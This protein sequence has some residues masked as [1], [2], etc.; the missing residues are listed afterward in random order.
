MLKT[1]TF[2]TN[3]IH[4]VRWINLII[5]WLCVIH[6]VIIYPLGWEYIIF[7]DILTTIL[8]LKKRKIL[9]NNSGI[10]GFLNDNQNFLKIH[11]VILRFAIMYYR[12]LFEPK[13][14]GNVK[15]KLEGCWNSFY[16]NVYYK[17]NK[18]SNIFPQIINPNS[19]FFH[20][21]Y[22]LSPKFKPYFF[23]FF[24]YYRLRFHCA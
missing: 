24:I 1:F 21:M 15:S 19:T 14:F 11:A 22:I 20:P 4:D 13:T 5:F 8:N 7:K 23:Q 16:S 2:N 6:F 18:L 3:C 10:L 17:I 12:N 9:R